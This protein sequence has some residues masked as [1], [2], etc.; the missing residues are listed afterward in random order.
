[1]ALLAY[2]IF[3]RTRFAVAECKVKSVD[4]MKQN[5]TEKQEFNGTNNDVSYKKFSVLIERFTTIHFVKLEVAIKML[6]QE[7]AK[8]QTRHCHNQFT[9]DRGVKHAQ[10]CDHRTSK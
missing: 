2:S 8:K 10:G 4:G 5:A 6:K 7:E 9:A 1:M 3:H